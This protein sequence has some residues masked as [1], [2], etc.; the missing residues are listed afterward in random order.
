MRINTRFKV[1]G[2][3]PDL[4]DQVFE[5]TERSTIADILEAAEP[6]LSRFRPMK[7]LEA[8]TFIVNNQYLASPLQ[9]ELHEGDEV[10]ILMPM[11]GG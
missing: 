6:I 9:Y 2:I 10:L 5:L 7:D 11:A 3:P 4:Q 1:F 8:A